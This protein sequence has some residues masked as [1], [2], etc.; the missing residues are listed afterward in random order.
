MVSRIRSYRHHEATATWFCPICGEGHPWETNESEPV[1][2][3]PRL[4]GAFRE[5]S[6]KV[7]AAGDRS[8]SAPCRLL[9]PL[10]GNP[11]DSQPAHV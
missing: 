9:V 6:S 5:R 2:I 7:T 3:T 10:D 1:R 8:M 11:H 4:T